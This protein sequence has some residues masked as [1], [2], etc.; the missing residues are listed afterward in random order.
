M[1][2]MVPRGLK[3]PATEYV[4]ANRARLAFR[5]AMIPLLQAHDALLSPT[6]PG[7]A[8]A[9]LGWTGDASLCAPWSSTG[10]PSLSLP[11]G[12]DDTGLPLAL[13]L[14]QAPGGTARLLGVA[15]WCEHVV[16]FAA[17]PRE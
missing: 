14:V 10:V 2:E 11:T 9:G 13:Q 15:A 6:A 16:G 4:T 7:T 3:R 1:A 17:R 12:V 5:E 8:P